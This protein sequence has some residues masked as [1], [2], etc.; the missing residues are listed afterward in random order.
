MLGGEERKCSLYGFVRS[1]WVQILCE[2][3]PLVGGE[4]SSIISTANWY[5]ID[6]SLCLYDP[7]SRRSDVLQSYRIFGVC[8]PVSLT[9][10]F[11]NRLVF[12]PGSPKSPYRA[13]EEQ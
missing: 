9:A 1:T 11:R 10:F 5:E 2:N 8:L 13:P 3:R 4:Y 7:I 12:H 6:I